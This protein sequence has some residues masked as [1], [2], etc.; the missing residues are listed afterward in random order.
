MDDARSGEVGG[1]GE[2][3]GRKEQDGAGKVSQ[4]QREKREEAHKPYSMS[5]GLTEHPWKRR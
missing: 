3:K 4:E 2:D 1:I 5:D